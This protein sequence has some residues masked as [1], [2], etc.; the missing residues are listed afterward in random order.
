MTRHCLLIA[1]T[2]TRRAPALSPLRGRMS[3]ICLGRGNKSGY[4][5]QGAEQGDTGIIAGVIAFQKDLYAAVMAD[6]A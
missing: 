3:R 2:R 6:A 1:V 5:G 4:G